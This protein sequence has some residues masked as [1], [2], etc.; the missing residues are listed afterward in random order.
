MTDQALKQAR[1]EQAQG[2]EAAMG[3]GAPGSMAVNVLSPTASK[4]A[5]SCLLAGQD[6]APGGFVFDGARRSEA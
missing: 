5:Y 1:L 2:K 6:A 3:G 4:R